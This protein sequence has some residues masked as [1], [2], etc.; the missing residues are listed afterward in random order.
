MTGRIA[1]VDLGVVNDTFFANFA[2][3]GLSSDIARNT[4]T[5]LKKIF[6]QVAYVLAGIGPLLRSSAFEATLKW[7]GDKATART[8]QLIVANGRYY[9]NVPLIPQ[10]TLIDRKLAVFTSNDLNRWD[11]ARMFVAFFFGKQTRLAEAE[12][13]CATDL[14]V[15]TKPKQKLDVD[16]EALGTTPARFSVAPKALRVM[17]PQEFTG[18]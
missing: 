4:P 2:T 10:A 1:G 6:G 17:V 12:Y 18:F 11:V 3:I 9:G 14:L 5:R 16:G 8:H 15:K 7:D 13:F